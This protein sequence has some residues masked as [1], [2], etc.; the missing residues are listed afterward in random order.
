VADVPLVGLTGEDLLHAISQQ[1][2][3][4]AGVHPVAEGL[5]DPQQLPGAAIVPRLESFPAAWIA[6]A[7]EHL[8]PGVVGLICSL[9][10]QRTFTRGLKR[11]RK[12]RT[13]SILNLWGLASIILCNPKKID[14]ASNLKRVFLRL[15]GDWQIAQEKEVAERFG[16]SGDQPSKCC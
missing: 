13:K 14:T 10:T 4:A 8:V 5:V 11:Q 16:P 9:H 15:Y 3:R 6:A 2:G 1:Y 7:I 12:T